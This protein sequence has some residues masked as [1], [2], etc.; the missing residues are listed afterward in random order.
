[1]F[2]VC[3]CLLSPLDGRLA[4]PDASPGADKQLLPTQED[5]IQDRVT[6]GL[7]FD[8]RDG[9]PEDEAESV[10][11]HMEAAQAG[12]PVSQ[13]VIASRYFHGSGLPKDDSEAYKWTRRSAEQGYKYAQF[14]LGYCYA[15][16]VG[17]GCPIRC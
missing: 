10:K 8:W 6:M 11:W 9:G 7:M 17:G 2:L 14:N 3:L 13:L 5:K 16:G 1:M 4:L 15:L 12:H